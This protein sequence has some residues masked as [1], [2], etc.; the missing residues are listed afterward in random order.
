VEERSA[1]DVRGRRGEKKGRHGGGRKGAGEM[2]RGCTCI[3]G[4]LLVDRGAA[5]QWTHAR[6]RRTT[7]GGTGGSHECRNTQA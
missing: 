1:T 2:M 4:L 6:E 7:V 3:G 5:G